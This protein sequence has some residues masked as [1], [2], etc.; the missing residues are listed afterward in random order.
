MRCGQAPSGACLRLASW[1]TEQDCLLPLGFPALRARR[2]IVVF[3][4]HAAGCRRPSRPPTSR[5]RVR[6]L[7]V[8]PL[9]SNFGSAVTA[10]KEQQP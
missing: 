10:A 1:V 2:P 9:P 7:S 5:L 6:Y 4:R 8:S 3:D